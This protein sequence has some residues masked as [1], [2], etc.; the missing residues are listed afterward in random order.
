MLINDYFNN[1]K[2]L[3]HEIS[4][5]DF[6]VN[7]FESRMKEIIIHGLNLNSK[8]FITSV[9]GWSTQSFLVMLENLLPDQ[10]RWQ[11][12]CLNSLVVKENFDIT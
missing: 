7:I 1:V 4:V 5:L 6:T 10:K 2:T 9:Q 11:G 12:K 3:Y 8:G